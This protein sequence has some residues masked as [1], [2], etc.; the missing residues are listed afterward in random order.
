MKKKI[1][2]SLLITNG[3]IVIAN[4]INKIN[5]EEADAK[6]LSFIK[7]LLTTDTL[8]NVQYWFIY[9]VIAASIICT[10]FT[11]LEK[12]KKGGAR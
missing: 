3:G 10:Y 12:S 2:I 4:L 6:I 5:T 9:L 8:L 11:M 7:N 1:T